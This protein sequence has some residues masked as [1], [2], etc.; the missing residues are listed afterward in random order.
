MAFADFYQ[1]FAGLGD[2]YE[3]SLQQYRRRE[4]GSMLSG[5]S[6]DYGQA[7][8]AAFGS[9]DLST[10][11]GLLKLS[12]DAKRLQLEQD[13]GAAFSR[14]LGSLFGGA[15]GGGLPSPGSPAPASGG[16]AGLGSLASVPAFTRA[17]QQYGL[18]P[19]Y[20]TA[21]YWTR[22]GLAKRPSIRPCPR[23]LSRRP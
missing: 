13:T 12:Q 10:G 11:L 20:L 7:A 3:K 18:D 9:G 8:Q 6:P 21:T 16:G 14:D 2:A 5:P 17:A 22:S 4:L 15:S 1:G 19:S 23:K